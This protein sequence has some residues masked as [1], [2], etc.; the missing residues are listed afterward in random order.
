MISKRLII[1]LTPG[2]L[3][4]GTL[5]FAVVKNNVQKVK[6]A[7]G[8][9]QMTLVLDAD[10]TPNTITA[11]YQDSVTGSVTTANGNSI[12]LSFVNAK[13]SSGNF[14]DLAPRGMVYNFASSNNHILGINGIK[15]TGSGTVYARTSKAGQPGGAVMND[16]E[17]L[18]SGTKMTFPTAEFFQ[19]MA[20][21]GGAV[22]TTLE[23]SFTCDGTLFDIAN[24]SGSYTG[25]GNDSITYKLDVTSAG[26]ATFQTL[27]KETNVSMSGT[28]QMLTASQ[29]KC[30]FTTGKT[31][32]YTWNIDSYKH[33]LTYVSKTG[34]NAGDVG[35]VNLNRIYDIE[36]FESYSATGNGYDSNRGAD[37]KYSMSGLRANWYA[38][39]YGSNTVPS[40]VGGS[41]WSL[42]GGNGDYLNFRSTGG[43]NNSKTASFKGNNNSLRYLTMNLFYGVPTATKGLILSFWAKGPYANTSYNSNATSS[44]TIKAYAYYATPVTPSNQTTAKTEEEFTIPVGSDWTEYTMELDPNKVYFGFGF[45]CKQNATT[46]TCIDDIKVYT[47]SPYAEYVEPAREYPEGTFKGTFTYKYSA[48]SSKTYNLVFAIGNDDNGL[49]EVLINNQKC[50]VTGITYNE[51][52]HKVSIGTV[53]SN[54]TID[55]ISSKKLGTITGTYNAAN[56]TITDVSFSGSIASGTYKITNNGSISMSR[57]T[58]YYDCDGTNNELLSIFKRRYGDPWTVDTG[59][60]DRITR[61]ATNYIS[62]T[63][64]VCVRGWSGGRVA[65]N[66]KDDFASATTL[67]NIAF[68]VYNPSGSNLTLRMWIYK[69]TSFGSNVEITSATAEAGTWTYVSVSFTSAAIYNFQIADFNNSGAYLSYDN[70]ALY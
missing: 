27:N 70:I 66:L 35:E 22:L 19:V 17:T 45:F 50:D 10:D 49:I 62:G 3:A 55:K 15:Y 48:S 2:L 8:T 59:N 29:M 68:W 44:A 4:V 9:D 47:A 12:N 46:Y 33:T 63:N 5:T 41:G 69:A 67:S 60:A 25:V 36:D 26:A 64:S 7:E 51:D 54:V 28:A 39:Y 57:P 65:L 21:D 37:S 11:S 14:V 24:M 32:D 38:D 1:G 52:S 30:S 34:T 23:I 31:V 18:T 56:N 53:N 16:F 58:K 61:N 40:P 42:M 6:P 13:S 20:G 43:R